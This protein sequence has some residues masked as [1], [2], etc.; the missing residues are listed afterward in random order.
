MVYLSFH[1]I[2][3]FFYKPANWFLLAF[4]LLCNNTLKKKNLSTEMTTA[5]YT[6][7]QFIATANVN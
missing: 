5:Q 4:T 2:V 6:L 3:D 7:Q 1:K